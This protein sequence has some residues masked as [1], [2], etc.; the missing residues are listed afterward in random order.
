MKSEDVAR[1]LVRIAKKLMGKKP[2][3]IATIS[4]TDTTSR[5]ARR[6]VPTK[7]QLVSK[8]AVL[9]TLEDIEFFVDRYKSVLKNT[10]LRIPEILRKHNDF[11]SDVN[12]L[13]THMEDYW[14]S[15]EGD[16]GY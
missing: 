9:E 7:E 4:C 10:P 12:L 14:K 3:K 8:E 2:K 16:E 13:K 1:E 6:P 15:I 5:V 11:V